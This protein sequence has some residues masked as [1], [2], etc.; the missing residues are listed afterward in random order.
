MLRS[1]W[2]SCAS[3]ADLTRRGGRKRHGKRPGSAPPTVG[4]LVRI[5]QPAG[6]L[7]YIGSRQITDAHR[8]DEGVVA[9]RQTNPGWL[10]ASSCRHDVANH[11]QR[12]GHSGNQ[13]A[14]M[15]HSSGTG[16]PGPNLYCGSALPVPLGILTEIAR[17]QLNITTICRTLIPIQI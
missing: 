1:L 17:L 15:N 13:L 14:T 8:R 12:D 3:R 5:H 16:S 7:G 6:R 9:T 10:F 11:R 4:R 2:R